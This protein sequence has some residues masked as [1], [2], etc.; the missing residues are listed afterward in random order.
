MMTF[1]EVTKELN[2]LYVA[3]NSDYGNSFNELLYEFGLI[4]VVI[5]LQDKM[6]RLKTIAKNDGEYCVKDETIRDTLM[7]L[8][9]Y[10]IM[11][12]MRL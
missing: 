5:R 3:K 6:N 10:S 12:L 2:E 8:A 4:T 11:A 7:D 1:E 9:N